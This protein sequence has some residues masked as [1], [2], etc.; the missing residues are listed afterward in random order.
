MALAGDE[1]GC[2]GRHC[3]EMNDC[4]EGLLLAGMCRTCVLA[5]AGAVLSNPPPAVSLLACNNHM[6]TVFGMLPVLLWE[7]LVLSGG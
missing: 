5:D 4:G 2:L 3:S 7:L 6:P 1:V